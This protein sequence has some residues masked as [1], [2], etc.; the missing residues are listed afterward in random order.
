M[1]NCE[2]A[3]VIKAIRQAGAVL[4]LANGVARI[5]GLTLIGPDLRTQAREHKGAIAAL[6][7]AEIQSIRGDLDSF[8]TRWETGCR[9]LAEDPERHK[10]PEALTRMREISNGWLEAREALEDLSPGDPAIK[11]AQQRLDAV[12][13]ETEG[14]SLVSLPRTG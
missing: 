11:A 12:S 5:N 10:R 8:I 6:L 1:T 4:Y 14:G 13:L 7:Q 3:E 2:P 9:W